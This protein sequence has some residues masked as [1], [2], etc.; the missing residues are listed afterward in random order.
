MAWDGAGNFVRTNGVNNGTQVWQNDRDAGTKVRADRHDT[1]DQDLAAGINA[2]LAKNGENTATANLKLGGFVLTGLGAG[3]SNGESVRY[4]QVVFSTGAQTVTGA[5]TWSDA[6]VF[7]STA[8]FN[9]LATFNANSLLTSSGTTLLEVESTDAGAGATCIIKLDRNSASP[10]SGDVIGKINFAGRNSVASEYGYSEINVYILDPTS[11]SEDAILRFRTVAAGTSAYRF[12]I[13]DGVYTANATGGDKGAD[14]I[15]AS[16]FYDD[17]FKLA[18][19]K[20]LSDPIV[21]SSDTLIDITGMSQFTDYV[22][23]FRNIVPSVT[24]VSLRMRTSTDNGVSFSSAFG[25]YGWY[26]SGYTNTG[27]T[28][29]FK[30]VAASSNDEVRFSDEN[31]S[32]VAANAGINGEL[33]LSNINSTTQNKNFRFNCVLFDRVFS[34]GASRNAIADIDAIRFYFTSGTIV[35]GTFYILGRS[36]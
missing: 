16:D 20:L 24:N 35:S 7:S 36:L 8:V 31:I 1:H 17:G 11:G 22:I 15:N 3:S 4:E 5:K 12:M 21:A 30:A 14:T 33:F 9:G 28:Y 19:Y 29:V 23:V 2:C 34:G 26:G 6:A 25:D 10:A 13:S 32:N 18:G 27:A